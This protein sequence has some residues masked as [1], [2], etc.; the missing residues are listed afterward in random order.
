M[1]LAVR[2]RIASDLPQDG[3]AGTGNRTYEVTENDA[4]RLS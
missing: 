2:N 3:E 1:K 4:D